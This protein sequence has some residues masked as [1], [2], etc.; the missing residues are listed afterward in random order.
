MDAFNVQI[1]S[2][3]TNNE[4]IMGKYALGTINEKDELFVDLKS[5]NRVHKCLSNKAIMVAY[6][7]K[8]YSR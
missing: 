7:I 3:N 2:D 8:K 4:L 1:D 6:P 5:L